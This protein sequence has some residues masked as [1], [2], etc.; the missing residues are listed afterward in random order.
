MDLVK[1]ALLYAAFLAPLAGVRARKA[2]TLPKVLAAQSALLA[3]FDALQAYAKGLN[4]EGAAAALTGFAVGV[5]A[6][7]LLLHRLEKR[8]KPPLEP[9][10]LWCAAASAFFAFSTVYAPLAP[11]EPAARRI[12]FHAA[13]A[14]V[15][16]SMVLHAADPVRVLSAL[17]MMSNALHPLLLES[18]KLAASLSNFSI[19][20]I[21]VVGAFAAVE[22]RREY[23]S[24]SLRVWDR[25]LRS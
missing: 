1:V 10:P 7:P 22:A 14:L 9:P 3:A 16:A 18:S 17:T 12:L 25:W 19:L 20:L 5:I 6:V 8:L 15:P 4:L 24:S 21:N 11:I 23:G 13:A 2:A